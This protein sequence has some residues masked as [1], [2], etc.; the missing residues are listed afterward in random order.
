[1]TSK[2]TRN[3]RSMLKLAGV[4]ASTALVAGC[5]ED[6]DNAEQAESD[7]AEGEEENVSADENESVG[8]ENG[9]ETD[10]NGNATDD[11]GG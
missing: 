11:E 8:E 5:S 7:D 4:A 3:R 10:E 1:M 9:E 2:R 6:D